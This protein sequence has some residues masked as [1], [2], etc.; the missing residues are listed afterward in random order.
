MSTPKKSKP[1]AELDLD[2][3]FFS[4]VSFANQGRDDS[5][6]PSSDSESE[7]EYSDTDGLDNFIDNSQEADKYIVFSEELDV[8][9]QKCQGDP[10]CAAPIDGIKKTFLGSLVTISGTCNNHHSFVWRSQPLKNRMPVGN[11]LLAGAILY[12]GNT[13]TTMSEIAE[14][15]KLKIFC[16][17]DFYYIQKKWLLPSINLMWTSHQEELLS[18]NII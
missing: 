15:L 2:C 1:D 14:C 13:Y 7:N 5:Y 3:S 16:D 11:L 4:D 10:L 9:F 8:L 18:G 17:R 12:T 6:H